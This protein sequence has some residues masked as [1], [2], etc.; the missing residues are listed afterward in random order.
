MIL[1]SRK[2]YVAVVLECLFG[3]SVTTVTIIEQ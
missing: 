3:R 2:F 1:M